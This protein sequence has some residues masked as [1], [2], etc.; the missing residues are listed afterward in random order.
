MLIAIYRFPC[1]PVGNSC[2]KIMGVKK[3]R[4]IYRPTGQ[5]ER[6]KQGVGWG[7]QVPGGDVSR[8]GA[9]GDNGWGEVSTCPSTHP[10]V[11]HR[12]LA[13]DPKG[14]GEELAHPG[15]LH[16]PD[17]LDLPGLGPCH[18]KSVPGQMS[19]GLRA[20]ESLVTSLIIIIFA[21]QSKG[22]SELDSA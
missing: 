10:S 12:P 13:V 20:I 8:D 7:Q 17:A 22:G 15:S 5:Q 16:S 6:N 18:P 2:N 1:I 14:P 3:G 11:P 4:A 9:V 19:Q 21:F